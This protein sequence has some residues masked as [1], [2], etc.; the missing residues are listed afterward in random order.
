MPSYPKFCLLL[1]EGNFF[2]VDMDGLVGMKVSLQSIS[3]ILLDC[4]SEK[5]YQLIGIACFQSGHYT[6]LCRI[7]G[8]RW[9]RFNDLE[10]GK[11]YDDVEDINEFIQP[12][13]CVYKKL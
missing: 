5:S 10:A 6:A 4:Q 2:Y 8:D 7:P 13:L 11:S 1:S 3:T 9:I 12:H